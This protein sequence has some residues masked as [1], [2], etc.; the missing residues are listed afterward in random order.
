MRNRRIVFA[1]I[2]VALA[3]EVLIAQGETDFKS[4]LLAKWDFD[5]G[6][7][8]VAQDASGNEHHGQM[9]A[10]TEG[11]APER[12][13]GMVGRAARF[14]AAAGVDITV[15]NHPRLNP[16]DGL[17]VAAWIKH[18]G[19]LPPGAEI[20]GK[21]GQAR[22]IVDGYR[23]FVSKAG[24]LFLSV[25]DGKEVCCVRTPRRAIRPSTWYHVAGTFSPGRIRLYLNGRM[26]ADQAV[27]AQRI[28]P[29]RNNLV[30]GN[31]AG[32]RNAL[33]WNGLIDEV[34]LFDRALD[35][36]AIFKSAAP[37]RLQQ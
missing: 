35:A 31:F 5:Q 12:V 28:E 2:V 26:V 13:K 33:P 8:R 22:A 10:L 19:P 17:T 37:E 23:F 36:D 15:K 1:S 3:N 34:N 20:V 27:A 6:E 14:S 4:H 7:G 11:A 30:I 21:K 9:G 32:R 25:G 24:R 18:E 29:S 16:I